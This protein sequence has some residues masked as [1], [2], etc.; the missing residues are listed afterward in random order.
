MTILY[1]LP[2]EKYRKTMISIKIKLGLK[3]DW[4]NKCVRKA[5]KTTEGKKNTGGLIKV[6]AYTQFL[7]RIFRRNLAYQYKRYKLGHSMEISWE[8]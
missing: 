5:K 8:T 6:F 3:E 4:N 2:T 7:A 1:S